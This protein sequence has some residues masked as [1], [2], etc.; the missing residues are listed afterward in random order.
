VV[1]IDSFGFLWR[2]LDRERVLWIRIG[3]SYRRT[4][5]IGQ[6]RLGLGSSQCLYRSLR[7]VDRVWDRTMSQPSDVKKRRVHPEFA[8][9]PTFQM[10][11]RQYELLG[12]ARQRIA[13]CFRNVGRC[14]VWAFLCLG[15]S[16]RVLACNVNAAARGRTYPWSCRHRI[17]T[18]YGKSTKFEFFSLWRRE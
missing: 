13:C 12:S 1:L 14:L 11:S 15:S 2:H 10:L 9:R 17:I 6:T 7:G 16:S 3:P 8:K 4:H 5:P 18:N